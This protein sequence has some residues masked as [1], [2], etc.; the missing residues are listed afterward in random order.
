MDTALPAIVRLSSLVVLVEAAIDVLVEAAM[1]SWIVSHSTNAAMEKLLII[2]AIKPINYFE[3]LD[4]YLHQC[5]QGR[6]P[7]QTE[8]LYF[9]LTVLSFAQNM[10]YFTEK[11]KIGPMS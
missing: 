8:Y 4:C 2:W 11:G 3:I 5:Y 1:T 6:M 9:Y 10:E 7:V